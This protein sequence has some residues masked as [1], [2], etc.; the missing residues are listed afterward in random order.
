MSSIA[1][2]LIALAFL[3]VYSSEAY[4]AAVGGVEDA[5]QR[6]HEVV[7]GDR[8][9]VRPVVV[10]QLEGVDQAVV[11]DLP[12]LGGARDHAAVGGLG[13]QAHEHVADDPVLPG[14][15]D[16]MRVERVGLAR[17]GDPKLAGGARRGAA[18]AE[19][20]GQAEGSP[21]RRTDA[22]TWQTSR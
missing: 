9:A 3:I 16:V 5:V 22:A 12:A 2:S 15:G 13:G 20:Q 6:E 7:G 8:H 11:A 21:A 10:A 18:E 19:R 17:V 1:P 14:T 4:S